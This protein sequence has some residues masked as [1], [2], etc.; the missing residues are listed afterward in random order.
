MRN[1]DWLMIG[2]CA[3]VPPPELVQEGRD[4]LQAMGFDLTVLK[5]VVQE[6]C[7]Y[8]GFDDPYVS[9]SAAPTPSS[10]TQCP[11]ANFTSAPS[12]DLTEWATNPLNV[13]SAISWFAQ[14]RW[15]SVVFVCSV[16]FR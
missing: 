6:G 1:D 8:E 5:S 11:P 10:T 15:F 12:L 4:I 13:T 7:L 9:P 16:I 3:Q 14:V 2:R